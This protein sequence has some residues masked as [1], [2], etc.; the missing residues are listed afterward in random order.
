MRHLIT[1]LLNCAWVTYIISATVIM[2]RIDKKGWFNRTWLWSKWPALASVLFDPL[3]KILFDHQSP[4][5]LDIFL[6]AVL[7]YLW[8]RYKDSGDDDEFKKLHKRLTESVKDLGGKLV[9]VPHPA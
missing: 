7:L 4:D 5:T 1:T 2:N 3:A 8:W 6:T 9:V